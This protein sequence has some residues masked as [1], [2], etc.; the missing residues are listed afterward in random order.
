MHQR[1]ADL[2]AR[3]FALLEALM[4]HPGLAQS[5]EDLLRDVWQYAHAPSTNVVD[6]YAGY[7]R[8]KLGPGVIE[9]VRGVGFRI[10]GP[11]DESLEG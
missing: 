10:S 8:R 7:L 5:R 2:S 1:V 6:V 4:R 11:V 3:E 9:T